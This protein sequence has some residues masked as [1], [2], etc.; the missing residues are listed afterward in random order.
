M[1]GQRRGKRRGGKTA[2]KKGDKTHRPSLPR[3]STPLAVTIGHIGGRGDGVAMAEVKLADQWEPREETFLFRT[4][5]PAK[6][7]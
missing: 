1:S 5:L 4:R 6:K 7:S 2:H 3:N